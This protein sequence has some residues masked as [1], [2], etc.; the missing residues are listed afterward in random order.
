MPVYINLPPEEEANALRE[1]ELKGLPKGWSVKETTRGK[2]RRRI[3]IAPITGQARDTIPQAIALSKELRILAGIAPLADLQSKKRKAP[4]NNNANNNKRAAKTPTAAAT[5][6][7]TNGGTR[8]AMA[9]A[10]VVNP[11][12]GAT[13]ATLPPPPAAGNVPRRPPPIAVSMNLQFANH[14]FHLTKSIHQQNEE[15]V[16]DLEAKLLKVKEKCAMSLSRMN[17]AKGLYDSVLLNFN[18]PNN[19]RGHTTVQNLNSAPPPA[20]ATA[21]NTKTGLPSP[22]TGAAAPV[23][24]RPATLSKQPRTLYDLW[25]EYTVGLGGR[26]PAMHFTSQE[27]TKVKS[28]YCRRKVVWDIVTALDCPAKEAIQ[29]IYNIYGAQTTVTK[30]IERI[31]KDRNNK[32]LNPILLPPPTAVGGSTTPKE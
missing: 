22:A 27:R 18:N 23:D 21:H 13:T 11:I 10:A 8:A 14:M 24:L 26:K 17:A 5:T 20:V 7:A 2:R 1:A 25:A 12:P 6:A 29:H 31:R 28:I 32:C 9:P 30:V 4:G 16:K 3:W 19:N 15:E